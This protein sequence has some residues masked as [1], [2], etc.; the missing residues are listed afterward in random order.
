MS[1]NG[2]AVHGRDRWL[3]HLSTIEPDAVDFLIGGPLFAE[4]HVNVYAGDGWQVARRDARLLEFHRD[5]GFAYR[6]TGLETI[7]RKD[8]LKVFYSGEP[9]RLRVRRSSRAGATGSLPPP[10]SP[11]PWS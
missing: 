7:D 8:V 11:A 4:L 5:T 2:A 9:G 3:I 10:R 6:V 1:C